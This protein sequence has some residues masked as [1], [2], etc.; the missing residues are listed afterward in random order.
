[1]GIVDMG[2]HV[3]SDMRRKF[4]LKTIAMFLIVNGDTQRFANGIKSMGDV[5]FHY[6]VN[7]GIQISK[8]LRK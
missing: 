1:M 7:I 8:T 5:N 2:R 3:T 6:I 4:A